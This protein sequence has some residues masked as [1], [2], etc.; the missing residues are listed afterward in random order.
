MFYILYYIMSKS[1][2]QMFECLTEHGAIEVSSWKSMY[3]N[4]K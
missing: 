1:I 4:N 3:N 2:S